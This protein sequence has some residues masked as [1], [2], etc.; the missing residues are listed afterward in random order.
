MSG[1][2]GRQYMRISKSIFFAII[3]LVTPGLINAAP[4]ALVGDKARCPVCG[5]FV[6][7]YDVWITQIR[8]S[9][10]VVH[11]FDGV[12]DMMAYFFDPVAYNGQPR[13]KIQEMWVKDYYSL[14][15]IEAR[16]AFFVTGSDVHGPMGHEF[17]PF[18][19]QVAAESFKTDHHGKEILAFEGITAE[20]V[21]KM[22]L[23]N[24][25]K[26]KRK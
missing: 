14:K 25:M 17:I 1:S 19:S 10:T 23:G 18:S 13:E 6:A 15:W 12:K 21:D 24:K 7:K 9:E 11:N 3:F 8:Y 5:M 4:D 26:Q 16:K 2:E 22:R 20:M